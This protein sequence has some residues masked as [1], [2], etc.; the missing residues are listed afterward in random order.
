MQHASGRRSSGVRAL[1]VDAA[2]ADRRRQIA[3]DGYESGRWSYA[4][5]R[6]AEDMAERRDL[7]T[8][9]EAW[10]EMLDE[11]EPALSSAAILACAEVFLDE[12]APESH[13]K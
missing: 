1:G 13:Q 2:L 12:C 7:P 3:A 5:V 6:V 10:C 11:L 8:E 4:A 9:D